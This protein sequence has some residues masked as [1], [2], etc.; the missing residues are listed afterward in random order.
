VP[1]RSLGVAAEMIFN[2]LGEVNADAAKG[3]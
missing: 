3:T 1:I 2:F